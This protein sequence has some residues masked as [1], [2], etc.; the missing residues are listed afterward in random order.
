FSEP[1]TAPGAPR[2]AVLSHKAWT[3]YF[4]SDPGILGRTI[5]LDNSA[6]T[7]IGVMPPRFTWN[8][9]DVWIPDAVDRGDPDGMKKEFWLQGRLKK[10]VSIAQAEAEF[11]AIG[12]RLAQIYPDR[13]PQRFRL[14]VIKVIDWVVGPFRN[15]LYTLF[16]AVGLL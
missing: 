2:V 4:G 14:S 13:Y 5:A 12:S 15:V 8:V 3:T 9:G 16:G 10:G 1:D 7:V 11:Q 6:M